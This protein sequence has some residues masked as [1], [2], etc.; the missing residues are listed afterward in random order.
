MI[1]GH[2]TVEALHHV[3]DVT[4]AEHASQ[5]RTGNA[6]NVMAT[7][8]ILPIGAL[9]LAGIRNIAAGLRRTARDQ[10][11]ALTLLGLT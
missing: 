4:Y 11:R 6:P 7:C 5:L 2:R 9:R 10:T 3:R 8:S 1:R